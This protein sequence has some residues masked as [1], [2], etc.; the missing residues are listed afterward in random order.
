MGSKIQNKK[1]SEL[2]IIFNSQKNYVLMESS[3]DEKNFELIKISPEFLI[4]C[5]VKNR[6]KK[7]KIKV[8]L[9]DFYLFT[10]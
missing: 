2:K 10:Q 5:R 7:K 8:N 4:I 6:I 1:I 3:Y 9:I